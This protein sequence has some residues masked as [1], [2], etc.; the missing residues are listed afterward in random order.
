MKTTNDVINLAFKA[1]DDDMNRIITL[2][3]IAE[4]HAGKYLNIVFTSPIN[5]SSAKL[6]YKSARFGM[7]KFNPHS[8]RY[9]RIGI[10]KI[11][12]RNSIKL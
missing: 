1:Y 2:R 8:Y 4:S 6:E 3:E 5:T 11:A 9:R 10:S 7:K 12:K